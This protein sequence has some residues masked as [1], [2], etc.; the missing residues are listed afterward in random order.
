MTAKAHPDNHNTNAVTVRKATIEDAAILF[1]FIKEL[2][3]YEKALDQVE[4]TEQSIASSLFAQD[5]N[6]YALICEHQ[7]Q[8][9]GS[10]IYFYN[11]STWQAKAGLY[12]EDLYVTPQA[13]GLGG[14]TALLKT[15]A[16]IALEKGCGRFE[17]SCLDWNTPSREFY[18]S[19]GAEDQTEWVRY[20]MNDTQMQQFI[21][22]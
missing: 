15:M 22:S 13:R 5:S 2:A 11:Y 12:L 20:R 21:A 10:A 16:N 8:A 17:W 6:S 7:G 3:V 18:A 19:I 14:G 9:I 4:A 1:Q